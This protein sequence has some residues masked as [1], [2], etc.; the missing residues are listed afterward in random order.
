MPALAGAG[1]AAVE[2]AVSLAF[3]SVP[4]LTT[5]DL[6]A[7]QAKPGQQLMLVDVRSPA[8]FA[9]SHLPGAIHFDGA[10]SAMPIPSG[11]VTVVVYCSVGYRS[12]EFAQALLLSQRKDSSDAV[13]I[14]NLRGSLF[15]WALEGR[16]LVDA[17]GQ[18]TRRVHGFNAFWA[19]LL[20]AD[21]VVLDSR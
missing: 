7:L 5:A 13:R 12:S 2:L 3:G 10:P 11:T 14:V 6:A 9:V 17:A 8:E 19:R 1:L 20:P 21:R 4:Q 16:P 15:R 18:P